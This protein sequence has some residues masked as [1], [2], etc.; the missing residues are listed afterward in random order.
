[1][2]FE[3]VISLVTVAFAQ[4]SYLPLNEYFELGWTFEEEDTIEFY[5]NVI[6]MKCP[7]VWGWC[8][9]TFAHGMNYTEMIIVGNFGGNENVTLYDFYSTGRMTPTQTIDIT[10]WII[11]DSSNSSGIFIS[12][13]RSLNTEQQFDKV[14]SVGLQT[15]FSFAYYLEKTSELVPHD[16]AFQGDIVFGSS[17]ATSSYTPFI[18]LPPDSFFALNQFFWL[19]WSFSPYGENINFYLSVIVI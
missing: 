12:F 13:I 11:T 8:G 3:V 6:L 2:L 4:D 14:L 1:M 17:N 19:G 5:L 15:S 9:F 16:N 18:A 7:N 10:D